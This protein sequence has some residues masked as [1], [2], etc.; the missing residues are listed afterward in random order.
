M[1]TKPQR[2]LGRGLDALFRGQQE[3][4]GG[5]A[6][7]MLSIAEVRPNPEQPRQIFSE[8][9]LSEL[10]ESI[11]AQGVLQP[12]LVRPASG[13]EG[14]YEIVAGERRWRAS[15][16][17]GQRTIPALVREMSSE[18]ALAIALIENLQREDL[19]PM[20]EAAGFRELRD[21]FG[22]SQEEISSRVGK[23]RSA[24]ANTLRL[25]NLPADIQE[26]LHNGRMTQGHARPL[27]A[28]DD[29]AVLPHLRQYILEQA[30]SVREVEG[31]IAQWKQNGE[32]PGKEAQVSAQAFARGKGAP[33]IPG[34]EHLALQEALAAVLGLPVRISGTLNKGRISI[35]FNSAE[36]LAALESRLGIK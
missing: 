22:L 11:R 24:V 28:V 35:N 13:D 12:I 21:R 23:S 20:E 36:D 31:W 27:L 3:N 4:E 1:M 6:V 17:A 26:D 7:Q 30:P 9:A 25:F 29:P 15:Q 33:K 10:A 14:K 18:Q 2:G 19:N 5:G 8:E 16:L 34:D 32:L